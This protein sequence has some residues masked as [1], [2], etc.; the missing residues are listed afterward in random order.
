RSWLCLLPKKPP[1]QHCKKLPGQ[2]RSSPEFAIELQQQG[3]STALGM[4]GRRQGPRSQQLGGLRADLA[5]QPV[6]FKVVHFLPG[7]CSWG[8]SKSKTPMGCVGISQAA[9]I[10]CGLS[11]TQ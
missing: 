8:S 6:W 3:C 10:P 7:S 2:Q 5:T 4:G 11:D 9:E 1:P